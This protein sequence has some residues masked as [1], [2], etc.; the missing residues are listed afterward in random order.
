MAAIAPARLPSRSEVAGWLVVSVVA[1]VSAVTWW[2]LLFLPLGDSH[3]GRIMG[4]FGLHIRNLWDNGL[5][6]SG[7]VTD[8]TPYPEAT[9]AHH[10]P[11]ANALHGLTSG[12]IG[13]GEWQ[14]R[15][16]GYVSGIATVFALAWLLRT[17]RFGWP[18]TIAGV[19][20]TAATPMF[21][22]YA[23]LGLGFW[24]VVLLVAVAVRV[25]RNEP[26]LRALLVLTAASALLSWEAIAV[27][28][29]TMAWLA[30]RARVRTAARA[31]AVVLVVSF[32]LVATWMLA[33]TDLTEL[34]GQATERITAPG[35]SLRAWVDNLWWFYTSLFQWW[36][37]VL[38]VPGLVVA[39]T[40]GRLGLRGERRAVVAIFGL[41]GVGMA[42]GLPEASFIH[43]YWTKILLVPFTIGL[44]ALVDKVPREA[45]RVALA[46]AAVALLVVWA[47]GEDQARFENAYFDQAS[48]AGRVLLAVGPPEGQ[49]V[50]WVAGP[51]ALPRWM[52]WY[53]EMPVEPLDSRAAFEELAAGTL[54]LVRSDQLPQWMSPADVARSVASAGRYHLIRSPG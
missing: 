40:A 14:L 45:I 18:A 35:I 33:A 36:Y 4:R 49:T 2:P 9:Y 27:A 13:Q 54:V 1:L 47:T 8:L 31:M 6:G 37:L 48:D 39:L 16:V 5:V 30:L 26:H 52:S 3:D 29:L 32:A 11:L 28:V 44:A 34:A 10:P 15:S 50:G 46:A 21:W 51:I 12:V 25:R 53:W 22:L 42:V 38:V 19:S 24:L 23:R 20:L 17:L 41:V 43:D 7:F